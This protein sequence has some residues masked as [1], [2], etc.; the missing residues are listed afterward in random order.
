MIIPPPIQHGDAIGIVAPASAVDPSLTQQAIALVTQQGY[1]PVLG[2]AI[3]DQY[4]YLAGSDDAR[5]NDLTQMF[6]DPDIKAIFCLRGGYGTLRIASRL[7]YR[8]ICHHPKWL[9]GYSDITTLLLAVYQQTTMLSIHGPMLAELPQSNNTS[10]WQT[11]W[12]M[13][14]HP[15]RCITYPSTKKA[16]CLFPG[17]AN[18]PIIGGNLS[19]VTASLGTPFE[20]DTEGKILFLE[21]VG[22]HPYRIDRMLTQL[23]LAGK[24]QSANGIIFGHVT[25][26]DPPKNK[27]SIPLLEML[28]EQMQLVGKPAYIGFPAGHSLPNVPILI[29]APAKMDA[30]TCC[31]TIFS[32]N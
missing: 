21:E 11:L 6:A 7:D 19:L 28:A 24:L 23:R 17:R 15:T 20:I 13:L 12:T 18:G 8:L 16:H 29:G 25:A 22:E 14:A 2:K 1:I 26:C 4:G 10:W 9:I 5:Y 31:C 30:T 32:D 3:Y 27:P